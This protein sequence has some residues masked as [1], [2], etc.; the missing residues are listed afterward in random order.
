MPSRD[1]QLGT[2]KRL[3]QRKL[4]T[5][6]VLFFSSLIEGIKFYFINFFLA[7]QKLR[8]LTP[9]LVWNCPGEP[10]CKGLKSQLAVIRRIARDQCLINFQLLLVCLSSCRRINP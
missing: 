2:G 5:I 8:V 7:L 3:I 6:P 9:G 10:Q 4:W 1:R